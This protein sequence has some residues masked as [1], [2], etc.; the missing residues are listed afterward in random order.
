MSKTTLIKSTLRA[1]ASKELQAEIE[2]DL[3]APET[4]E[5]RR[6]VAKLLEQTQ[7]ESKSHHDKAKN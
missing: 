7:Y 5:S 1:V 4:Q 2:R 3:E 6:A